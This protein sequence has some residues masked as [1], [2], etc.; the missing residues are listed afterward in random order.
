M[1]K[2]IY[3]LFVLIAYLLGS[4]PFGLL[5]SK[6]RGVDIRATGSG[7]IGATN[8]GRALGLK[9]FILVFLLDFLKGALPTYFFAVFL[10]TNFPCPT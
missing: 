5:I 9:F 3:A 2:L 7:N 4:I 10:V 1:Q 8:V 6:K